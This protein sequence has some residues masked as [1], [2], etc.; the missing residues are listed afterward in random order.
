M[1]ILSKRFLE[2]TYFFSCDFH[3]FEG[4]IGCATKFHDDEISFFLSISVT[5]KAIAFF[6]KK[7]PELNTLSV[8]A[9]D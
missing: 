2:K 1:A 7:N 9:I 3:I 6:I 4:S 5:S 8:I